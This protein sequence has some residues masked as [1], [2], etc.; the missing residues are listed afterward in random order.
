MWR[1]SSVS[2][3]LPNDPS[4]VGV[5]LYAQALLVQYPFLSHLTNLTADQVWR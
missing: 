5:T 3:V 4:L 2:V 1:T